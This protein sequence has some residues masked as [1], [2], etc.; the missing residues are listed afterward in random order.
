MFKICKNCEA[1]WNDAIDFVGDKEVKFI[2]YQA[3]FDRAKSGLFLF[4][5]ACQST[6]SIKLNE[7]E[8]LSV[9]KL[10]VTSFTPG[11]ASC[12]GYCL[13]VHNLIACENNECQGKSIRDLVQIIKLYQAR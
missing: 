12:K 1:V 5:H 10:Q 11:S 8:Q 4:N 6:L 13:D 2:G 9:L 3:R 7:F